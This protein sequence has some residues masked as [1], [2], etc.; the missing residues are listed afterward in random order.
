MTFASI[1]SRFAFSKV[2]VKFMYGVGLRDL[3][4]GHAETRH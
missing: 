1:N 4:Y 2:I 3:K